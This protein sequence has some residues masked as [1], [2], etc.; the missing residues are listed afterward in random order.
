[1]SST[2]LKLALNEGKISKI[3]HASSKDYILDMQISLMPDPD[4]INVKAT[5]DTGLNKRPKKKKK[6]R[7]KTAKNGTGK[8][9]LVDEFTDEE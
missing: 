3:M 7:V 5:I 4:L 6:K 2:K 8:E 1:M 9:M